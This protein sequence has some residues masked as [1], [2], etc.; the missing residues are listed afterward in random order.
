MDLIT[1][2]VAN[3]SPRDDLPITEFDGTTVLCRVCGD[4]ASGF[5]YGVHSCEGCKGFFR[6]S[7]QQKIQYRPCTKNQQCSILRINR[8]RCQYCRLKKCIAVG[9][10]RDAVRFGR[11]PKREKAKILAAMQSVNARS[12]E[13][14]V[15]AELEDNTRVTAAIIRAHMDTCDFTRDKVAPMLQQARAQ[16]SFTQC[17][18]TL[19]CPLNPILPQACPLNPRPVPLHGQQEL[20]QD[21]SERFSP[22]IRGVVEFAKRLPGFQQLPQE[23][24]VTL[25]KAGVFEVLLVR[26]AAMF[27]ARSNTMLCLNGQLLRREALHTSVN[28]R[29]LVDS[30]FDFAERLNSLCLSDAELALFCAVVVLAPDRPGLRNAEL[31]ER[32]QRHLVNCLQTVVS[33]HHPENPSLHRELLAKI[34]DLRTLNTLH[35]EK[36]LKY[37]MTEHTA[38]TSGPWDDSRSSWSMEQESSVGSPSSSC[39]ADEA[40]RSPVSCSESMYSGESASSGESLCGSEVSGYTELRPPFPLARRR[41]DNSEGASSGDEATESPLKCPFSKRKSDSPDDSG[42]ESGTDR[43]DKL[44]SPSVCS[45][46]RSSIDE[47][48]EEDREE[49]MSVL[50]R[51]LQAPPIINT[52]LLMEEAYKPHKKFRALRREEEPHSSQPTPSLLAQ[53]LAQPPQSSSSLAA[54]HST[55]ASTLCSPSL[56]ASHST[57][58][59]TLL[60]GSKISEDTMRRADLLH[61]MIMRNEVRERLPSGS[62]VSPAP[63]YIPQ[64]AMDRLQLPASSWSCPSSRG[65]SSSSSGSMS[66]MQ[67]TVTAQ[68]RV[69]LLTTPTPSRYYEPR[70][71]TTPVGLGAQPSPSPDAPAPSPSQGMEIQHTGM[72]AQPHQRSSSS[73]MVELQV[74]IADSQPL[75]LSKKTPP[76]TPQEFILEA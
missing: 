21:F 54:T 55:L 48:S 35:S 8:N 68:P 36:L 2:M 26:L 3:M 73:P 74:D 30:M 65:A 59:R 25:L 40:M 9:M 10:S 29:F 49:D 23:D 53:T 76:P 67:P 47:K 51:A 75:N 38:A 1:R 46:P 39:A 42:I 4:K 32:V 24:Q 62:R 66:P 44:S 19:A 13:R 70:M 31:V 52:D 14:A 27:D 5:H 18:P 12:Q 63:Y 71:S 72:G 28:A 7:I 34:P 6:R 45:S 60:E 37:K 43:S 58:A 50:R 61:S 64:P 17:P 57:L 15:L 20:V 33:K 41:H 11:V 16:P 69:H 56:A 22:A